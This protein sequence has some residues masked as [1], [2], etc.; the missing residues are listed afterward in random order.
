MPYMRCRRI[1]F[2]SVYRY[3]F[4]GRKKAMSY[5]L[6]LR[7]I[8]RNFWTRMI[9]T[10]AG[11]V[12]RSAGWIIHTKSHEQITKI[13][14]WCFIQRHGRRNRKRG[15][16]RYFGVYQN[17]TKTLRQPILKTEKED[18]LLPSL[19]F[20][21]VWTGSQNRTPLRSVAFGALLLGFCWKHP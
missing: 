9:F 17:W 3:R 13:K 16:Y 15:I 6:K 14:V 8:F 18:I 12:H 1:K 11:T 2:V 7:I 5:K 21:P 19:L 10:S 20:L 4:L